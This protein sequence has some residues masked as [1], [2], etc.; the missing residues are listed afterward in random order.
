MRRLWETTYS[1]TVL[2]P[3]ALRAAFPG[4]CGVISNGKLWIWKSRDVPREE[5]NLLDSTSDLLYLKSIQHLSKA[6]QMSKANDTQSENMSM[7]NIFGLLLGSWWLKY[8]SLIWTFFI[9]KA[10]QTGFS[11]EQL[12][13]PADYTLV[14]LCIFKQRWNWKNKQT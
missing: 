14:N 12:E 6:Q 5:P 9:W 2:T 4:H 13:T 11:N 1:F 3:K 7:V 8:L 10:N